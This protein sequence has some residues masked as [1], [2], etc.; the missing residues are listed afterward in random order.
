VALI[1]VAGSQSS[2]LHFP[3]ISLPKTYTNSYET[4]E[5][6][7]ANIETFIE[8]Y[9][10]QQ[11]L[12]SAFGDRSRSLNNK[13]VPRWDCKFEGATITFFA[14]LDQSSTGMLELA[15]YGEDAG[16]AGAAALCE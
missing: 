12:H 3:T 13:Y 5:Y 4:L 8:Q 9:Y 11:R 2:L 10:N 1:P 7:R 15:H 6:L 16:I 14:G